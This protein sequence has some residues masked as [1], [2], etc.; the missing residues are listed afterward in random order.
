[1][2]PVRRAP[3][4]LMLLMTASPAVSA[5]PYELA[6][7]AQAL[8]SEFGATY[9]AEVDG[10]EP[11]GAVRKSLLHVL[12]SA[13]AGNS[14]CAFGLDIETIKNEARQLSGG[15]PNK[16]DPFLD[17]RR[18]VSEET[19]SDLETDKA[20][21]CQHI[22]ALYQ[23]SVPWIELELAQVAARHSSGFAL[24]EEQ[25]DDQAQIVPVN[26]SNPAVDATADTAII[27]IMFSEDTVRVPVKFDP[28]MPGKPLID[29][30]RMITD[31]SFAGQTFPDYICPPHSSPLAC[32]TMFEGNARVLKS[33][34]TGDY[35]PSEFLCQDTRTQAAIKG[36]AN[37]A[38]ALQMAMLQATL[39]ASG[40]ELS[41]DKLSFNPG[42]YYLYRFLMAG[43][44]C[45]GLR[46]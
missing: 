20:R 29:L 15:E 5:T 11:S 2:K 12:A 8:R 17:L 44:V 43:E 30:E 46:Q 9:F 18:A 24:P 7:A 45:L 28:S 10:S 23:Q 39:T 25:P 32:A 33:N 41:E 36:T 6:H 3:L 19:R 1:M 21:T 42:G 26:A 37:Y 4:I 13:L 40:V 16:A 14:A 35:Q 38:T 27:P 34:V 31:Q 22:G